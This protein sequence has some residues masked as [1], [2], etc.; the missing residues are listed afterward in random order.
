M[1]KYF[2]ADKTFSLFTPRRHLCHLRRRRCRHRHLCHRRR[3]RCCHCQRR[4][5]RRR[6]VNGFLSVSVIKSCIKLSN[7][8]MKEHKWEKIIRIRWLL[9]R[10]IYC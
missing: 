10:A 2:I 6:N 1:F 7:Y 5:H 3:R 9:S 4:R 8:D